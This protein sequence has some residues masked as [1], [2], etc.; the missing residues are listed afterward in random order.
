MDSD[1]NTVE[2]SSKDTNLVFNRNKTKVMVISSQQMVQYHQPDS[3][4]KANIKYNNTNIERVKEY[5]LLGIILDEHFELHSHINKKVVI[6]LY[7][8]L[9]Y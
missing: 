7:E 2:V 5:K 4:N 9:N 8:H 3:S 1:L 6:P